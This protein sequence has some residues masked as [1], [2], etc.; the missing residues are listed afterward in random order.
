[1]LRLLMTGA[2]PFFGRVGLGP[3]SGDGARRGSTAT[4]LTDLRV[5]WEAP[6]GRAQELRTPQ[7]FTLVREGRRWRFADAYFLRFAGAYQVQKPF[8]QR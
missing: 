6:N 1:M 5:R 8:P 7:S 2:A 4:V 3:L